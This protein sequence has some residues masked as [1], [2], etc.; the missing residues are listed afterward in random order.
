MEQPPV[1]TTATGNCKPS[2]EIASGYD[3]S[4]KLNVPGD[5]MSNKEGEE[6]A[7]HDSITTG[8]SFGSFND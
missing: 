2:K 3:G 1:G 4:L 5:G 7:G 8:S 6:S